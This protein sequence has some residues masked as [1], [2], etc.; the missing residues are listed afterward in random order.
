VR[1][2][3]T[4]VARLLRAHGRARSRRTARLS[5]APH[6]AL[7]SAVA[8]GAHSRGFAPFAAHRN[9]RR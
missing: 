7:M 3:C 8:C 9:A 1:A 2:E 5:A 6:A 4:A